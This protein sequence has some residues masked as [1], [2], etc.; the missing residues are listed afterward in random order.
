MLQNTS[1]WARLKTW[2]PRTSW[3][4]RKFFSKFSESEFLVLAIGQNQKLGHKK[5]RN[6]IS[7]IS[8]ISDFS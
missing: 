2:K 8:E 4:L 3:K 6:N 5:T 1:Q 7:K